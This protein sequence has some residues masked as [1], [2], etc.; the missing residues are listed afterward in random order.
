MPELAAAPKTP[1]RIHLEQLTKGDTARIESSDLSDDD[2]AMLRALGL[3]PEAPF[4]VCRLGHTCIV[5]MCD[6]LGSGCRIGISRSLAK[7]LVVSRDGS[8]D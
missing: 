7:R 5:E 1:V 2:T 4:K 3:R 8:A 6:R